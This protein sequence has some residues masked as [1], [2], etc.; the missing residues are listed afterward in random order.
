MAP[1]TASTAVAIAIVSLRLRFMA[2]RFLTRISIL[3]LGLGTAYHTLQ[4]LI[5]RSLVFS[6]SLNSIYVQHAGARRLRWPG[7]YCGRFAD[8]TA[9]IDVQCRPRTTFPLAHR[10]AR[11]PRV[12]HRRLRELGLNTDGEF[13]PISWEAPG[14]VASRR[15]NSGSEP[16]ARQVLRAAI[17]PTGGHTGAV[18]IEARIM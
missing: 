6:L 10:S 15:L 2:D 4:K 16:E 3:A 7:S 17:L 18:R 11:S 5:L 8:D 14:R 1:R 12:L 13:E 9:M